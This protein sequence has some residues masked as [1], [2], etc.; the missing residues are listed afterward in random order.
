MATYDLD[1]QEKIDALKA[2]WKHNGN[3]VILAVSIFAVTVVGVQGWRQYQN[4][5]ALKASM[6]YDALQNLAKRG[7][8][9]KVRDSAGQL[10]DQYSGTAYAP[11][12]ALIAAKANHEAG[13]TQSARAQ[14]QWAAEHAKEEEVRDTAK[15]RLAG[16]LLDEKNY[17][18]ALKQLESTPNPS[19]AALFFD[20]RG[21]ILTAQEKLAE[22]RAAYKAALDKIEN[23]SAYRQ[24]I[25]MKM[26]NLGS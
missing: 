3:T 6:T 20:M 9:K 1:E 4:S 2:W 15:L 17:A 16:V 24:V 12:A 5:Q 10:I 22:A 13:D 7:E 8:V 21:D 26:E 19:F 18:E 14:L 25:K 11:R 23:K